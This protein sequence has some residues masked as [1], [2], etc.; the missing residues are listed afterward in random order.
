VIVEKKLA[1]SVEEYRDRLGRI[2]ATMAAR[3]LDVLVLHTPENI[4]YVSGFHT[5]GYYFPQILVVSADKDPLLVAR[6]LETKNADAFSWLEPDH[7]V[8]Y[9]DTDNPAAVFADELRRRGLDRGR[10][11]IE[12]SGYAF[13]PIDRYEQLQAA[14]GNARLENGSGI[15][16]QERAV[17][18]PREIAYIR[19][20]CRISDAGM[21]AA[22][23]HCRAGVTENKLAGF[24]HKAMVELGGEYPGLPLFLSSGR[25]TYVSHATWTDKK[26]AH[27][28]NVLVEHTGVV[29]RYAGPLFRTL[30]VGPPAPAFRANARICADVLNAVIAAIRPG[31]TSHDVNGAALEA[32]RAAGLDAGIRKRAG[33]S[34]GLNFP[35]DW[36]EGVFLDL[37]D[38][39]PTVL[40]PGMVFHLP[41]SLRRGDDVPVALSETVLVTETGNEVLTKF[42]RRRL[43]VV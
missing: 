36:G 43:I 7:V 30:S 23:R 15:V 16:E 2:R 29:M 22:V 42:G 18:S 40:K 14:L 26:I 3:G 41:Q 28:D 35:P 10:I 11:G 5:P 31:A 13:L 37:K 34:I 19:R 24:I 32:A 20:A 4:C 8:G 12:K 21:K 27:G 39:D 38:G 1:F 6:R 25:R 17:K 9:L 33:Y